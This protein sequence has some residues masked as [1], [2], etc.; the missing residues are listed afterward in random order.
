M[1][2]QDLI[3]KDSIVL[4]KNYKVCAAHFQTNMFL[5]DLQNRLHV[6]AIPTVFENTRTN[7]F[8]TETRTE[9]IQANTLNTNMPENQP[10]IPSIMM[11][12]NYSC[13]T[14]ET[15]ISKEVSTQET[16]NSEEVLIEESTIWEEVSTQETTISEEVLTEESRNF[17]AKRNKPSPLVIRIPDNQLSPPLEKSPSA[18]TQTSHILSANSPRKEKLRTKLKKLQRIK[19]I[20]EA[21]LKL[22]SMKIFYFFDMPHLMKAVRNNMITHNFIYDDQYVSWQHIKHF[23]E[24]DKIRNL[25]LAPKLTKEHIYP[26]NWQKMRVKYAMQVLS[27]T[28]VAAL[29]TYI[30]FGALGEAMGTANFISDFDKL[31][32]IFNSS[33]LFNAKEF[34][35][36]FKGEQYQI[37]FFI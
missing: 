15:T 34:N 28:L 6:H 30:S 20:L 26:N 18:L 27:A 32:D 25:R 22:N 29:K 8:R 12:T 21:K 7:D 31:F 14:E 33:K 36:P 37:D 5:N 13:S 16:I 1:N 23:Y 9:T 10:E 17:C 2:R 35:K 19:S 4:Y 24:Q 3:N 11:D